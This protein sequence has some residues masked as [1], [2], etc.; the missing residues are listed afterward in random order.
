MPEPVPTVFDEIFA[1]LT[2][3][4]IFGDPRATGA[5]VAVAVIDSGVERSVLEDKFRAAGTPIQPIEGAVFR[6]S[7]PSAS[8]GEARP[9]PPLEYTGH[10]S[11]PHG[12][13]VAD[14]I[15]T[16][17]PQVKLYSADVFGAAGSCEVE[18]VIAAL[19][20]ALDVWKVKVVNLSLGVPEHKLQQLPRRQQLQRAIEE[21]YFRDV[22]VFAAAHNEHPLT[23][24]Y[25]AAFAPP[26]I[27]VDKGLF[28]DPLGF[29]YK[30][31]EHVEF[32][33]HGKGY[34]GPLAREPAT[35]WAT[36]HLAGIAA[37]ILSLKPDLKPFEIK[38]ILYWLFR[39][40]SGGS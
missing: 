11:S 12:T 8:G 31:S 25:P 28:A 35:S 38:T 37:R 9:A 3:D 21:A 1:R 33:A 10:Q 19:R 20:Y 4:S 24:S 15:L 26:L 2:P 5:G 7:V 16:L 6:S 22:L 29:A 14:I 17:A 18:T 13:T 27:S 40:G 30:L 32:Q 39:S 34:L 23:R 36:P